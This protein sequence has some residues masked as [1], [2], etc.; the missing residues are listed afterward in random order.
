M[1]T[2]TEFSSTGVL[3]AAGDK[4]GGRSCRFEREYNFRSKFV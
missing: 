4:S 2:S 1:K 3:T